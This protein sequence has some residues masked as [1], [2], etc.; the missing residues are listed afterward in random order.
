MKMI[1]TFLG[2]M[3]SA[4]VASMVIYFLVVPPLQEDLLLATQ[5]LELSAYYESE[6]LMLTKTPQE[7]YEYIASKQCSNLEYLEENL[8]YFSNL[9]NS[10]GEIYVELIQGVMASISN[11]H[12]HAGVICQK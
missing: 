3:F 9:E 8:R 1:F 6:A 2:G 11:H 5:V 4:F 12:S 7:A 10:L